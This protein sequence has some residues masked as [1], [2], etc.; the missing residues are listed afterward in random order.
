MH[1]QAALR[2]AASAQI[3]RPAKPAVL[4]MTRLEGKRAAEASKLR[5]QSSKL[6][7]QS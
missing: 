3:L 6:K 2:M 1:S 7:A 5:A 4:R